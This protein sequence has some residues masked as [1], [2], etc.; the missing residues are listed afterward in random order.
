M[1]GAKFESQIE[2]RNKAGAPTQRRC[3]RCK[4]RMALKSISAG[5][6]GFEH[7][8]FGCAICDYV[9]ETVVAVDPRRTRAVGWLDTT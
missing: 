4:A 3:A 6:V 1:P 2:G 8:T 7:R 9:E 5:P